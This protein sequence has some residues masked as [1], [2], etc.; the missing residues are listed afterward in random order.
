MWPLSSTLP[1]RDDSCIALC[2][3]GSLIQIKDIFELVGLGGYLLGAAEHSGCCTANVA[4]TGF[5][6]YDCMLLNRPKPS[7]YVQVTVDV[8][9]GGNA[10]ETQDE[11]RSL[12]FPMQQC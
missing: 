6:S 12:T 9:P 4:D 10:E 1:S 3:V 11:H 7:L 2:T 8:R 5:M